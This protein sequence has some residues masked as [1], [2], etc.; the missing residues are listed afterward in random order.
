MSLPSGM[1][2]RTL[3][4]S[5]GVGISGTRSSLEVLVEV[6]P[7]TV[8]WLPTA[9]P[10][11]SL[12]PL[13]RTTVPDVAAVLQLPTVDQP[14]FS[15]DFYYKITVRYLADGRKIG[16]TKT[17]FYRPRNS[18]AEIEDFDLLS[19]TTTPPES[20]GPPGPQGPQGP[21]GEPGEAVLN[22][23]IS[24]VHEQ[25]TPESVWV[26][27]H[28]LSF[29]PNVTIVDSAGTRLWGAEVYLPETNTIIVTF[30]GGFS[31]TAYLS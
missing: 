31:G 12:L 29:M 18:S 25:L 5:T 6:V 19:D 10:L 2:T 17:R 11:M 15:E 22:G 24:Y 20:I 23:A 9:E 16:R 27:T 7:E 8:V 30:S 21:K 28:P 1:T 3:T 13:R 4:I 14:G 26:I